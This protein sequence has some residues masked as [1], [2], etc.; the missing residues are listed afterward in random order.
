MG[1]TSVYKN[2]CNPN[3]PDPF[4]PPPSPPPGLPLPSLPRAL[5]QA[6][7][8]V[9]GGLLDARVTAP[10]D[11]P[12]ASAAAPGPSA[13]PVPPPPVTSPTSEPSPPRASG[14]LRRRRLQGPPEAHAPGSS[15]VFLHPHRPHRTGPSRTNAARDE[16][17]SLSLSPNLPFRSTADPTGV[18]NEDWLQGHQMGMYPD[19]LDQNG[20]KQ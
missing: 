19:S 5:L 13:K 14:R 4:H 18:E 6:R 11:L 7:A 12:A 16:V 1:P 3:Q 15:L 20:R 8:A 10:E 9:P 2:F 17:P